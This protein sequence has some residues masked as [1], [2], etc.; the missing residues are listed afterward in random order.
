MEAKLSPRAAQRVAREA[1]TQS[2]ANA[3]RALNIDWGAAYDGKQIQRMSEA[4]GATLVKQRDAEVEAY[5]RGQR[6]PGPANDPP[7]LV[8]GV[9]GGR[10]QSREKNSETGSRW[11]EDKVLTITSYLPGDGQEKKPVKLV[12]TCVAT[13]GDCKAFGKLARVEAERRGIR[14]ALRTIVIGDGGNWIDPL[15]QDHFFRH[16]RL[17]DYYH[18][19]E[20]LHEVAHAVH[21]N[22]PPQADT[23]ADQ[24]KEHLWEGRTQ[25]L[26]D[27]LKGHAA[28]AG[29]PQ[30]TDTADH[31]RQV[32]ARNLGY[33]ERH[34]EHMNYPEYRRQGWP[35]ASGITESGVK[36]FG[37]RVKG[38]EQFWSDTGVEAILALRAL[39]L[40]DDER[41]DHY[42]RYGSYRKK[43]A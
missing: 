28:S 13:M 16:P 23:L 24:L 21:A 32:L 29:P 2:F 27:L 18:A 22:H 19:A 12:T 30:P 9:D 33:F 8:I 10:V 37:K 6:P 34:R 25:T 42:W 26:I 5:E 3:A 31:P 14:Q 4:L 15:W 17:I 11:R 39:W 20:H 43:A 7:L 38:T 36:R 35:I 1:A 41:W 40:S